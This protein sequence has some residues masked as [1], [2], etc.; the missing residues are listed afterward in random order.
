MR[1][2][3]R[4]PIYIEEAWLDRHG[5]AVGAALVLASVVVAAL[6]LAWALGGA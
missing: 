3:T 4:D 5:R 2:P 1:K 6:A